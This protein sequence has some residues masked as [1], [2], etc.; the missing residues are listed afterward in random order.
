MLIK[1]SNPIDK[2]KAIE[3]FNKLIN[4]DCI[5]EL[6]EKKPKRSNSQNRYLHLILNWFC[7]ETG[8][9]LDYT[10]SMIYKTLVNSELFEFVIKGK[11]GDVKAL[12][13]SSDLDSREMTLSIERFRNWSSKNGV[14]L[15]SPD[16]KEYLQEI[17]YQISKQKQYL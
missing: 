7:L 6:T 5:F 14:Y 13:S 4:K 10:K 12:K 11:L 15:P 17:E 3:Q 9:P 2:Q 8:Y 16:E 1:T